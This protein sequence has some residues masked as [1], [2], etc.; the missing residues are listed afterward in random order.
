MMQG[1]LPHARLAAFGFGLGATVSAVG[2]S[3]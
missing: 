3:E 2:F 1:I